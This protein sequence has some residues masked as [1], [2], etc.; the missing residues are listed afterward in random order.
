MNPSQMRTYVTRF[1][2][3]VMLYVITGIL[4]LNI[5]PVNVFATLF[6]PPTGISLAALLIWG[7][8][9]WP[10]IA[11][12][13]FLTNYIKGAS[14]YVAIGIAVG[15]TLEPLV[16]S[17]LLGRVI[18]I[19]KSLDRLRDVLAMVSI[20]IFVMCPISALLGSLSLW[21]G[22]QSSSQALPGT[23]L[24]WWIGDVISALIISPFLLVWSEW[25]FNTRIPLKRAIEMVLLATLIILAG[26]HILEEQTAVSG[27]GL[28]L[29]FLVFPLLIWAALRFGQR[30]AATASFAVSIFATSGALNSTGS[31][32][33]SAQLEG[34]Y[35]TQV[36]QGSVA[37]TSLI[38]G[39]VVTELRKANESLLES[40][41]RLKLASEFGKIG[42]WEWNMVTDHLIWNPQHERQMGYK[43][44]QNYHHLDDFAQRVHPDD[45]N[46]VE[47]KRQKAIETK[48]TFEMEYRI[49]LPDQ[50][51]RWI[52]AKGRAV[53]DPSGKPKRMLGANIDITE[54]KNAEITRNFIEKVTAEMGVNL[55]YEGTL[56]R[57]TQLMVP[58]LCNWCILH[59]YEN[60]TFV[61]RSVSH[62]DPD[63]EKL[64][65]SSLLR[66]P[67][68]LSDQHGVG[69]VIRTGKPEIYP[70]IDAQW[71]TQALGA[72]YPEIFRVLGTQS[73]M[74]VPL[75][76][77]GEVF[78]A[79][80][81]I[82]GT[83]GRRYSAT[84]LSLAEEL[85]LRASLALDNA[86]SYGA[87]NQAVALRDEFMSIAS[88]E[89]KTPL[90]P[91]KIQLGMIQKIVTK[92][93]STLGPMGDL[94]LDITE[95]SKQQ[96]DRLVILI[97]DLLD[98]T[99]ITAGK[100][101]LNLEDVDLPGLV[102]E[103]V[104]RF[105]PEIDHAQCTLE[106]ELTTPTKGRW[107][108][109]RIEQVVTNLL[110]NAIKYGGGK[111]IKISVLSDQNVAWLSVKDQGIGINKDD[112]RRIFGKFERAAETQH[113]T[114]L[115]LG[116][117][118]TRK[119]IES[120]GGLIHLESEL[121]KGSIFT[122]ELPLEMSIGELKERK[123]K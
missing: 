40:E 120:H 75:Q 106:V 122:V 34:L 43:P 119:I 89:M 31:L 78:G 85:A 73:F 86:R 88:H 64:A 87:A 113:I 94:V 121:G 100:L 93:Q 105:Q 5:R 32:S 28:P 114:G 4:G 111:P 117:F 48:S 19:R 39:A 44:G 79:L 29:R 51:V 90:T 13:A 52:S 21:L 99:R 66:F 97:D 10:A 18:G 80:S 71:L 55:D 49:L 1:I 112:Q 27:H 102:R 104:G 83:S 12:G 77:H 68:R 8:Q 91:L 101:K 109:T 115:G 36:F 42:M 38:L 15:N 22:N 17:L 72:E 54:R 41:S 35:V 84:D 2:V 108:R 57:I 25:T 60:D 74:C 23:V 59:I 9:L 45:R 47:K 53:Y 81:F 7:S 6:W 82:F 11:L 98:V 50:T 116:L 20:I 107:D 103:V 56:R 62:V 65:Q 58:D 70:N 26:K 69:S 110:T 95:K 76:A 3:V 16:G 118:I 24:A 61:A 33:G 63:N 30:G 46:L 96:V 123:V 92:G 37:I 67:I 14:A